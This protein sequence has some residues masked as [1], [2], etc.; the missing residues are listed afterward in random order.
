MAVS[1]RAARTLAAHF[2]VGMWL[3]GRGDV[4]R[5]AVTDVF[6]PLADWEPL[7]VGRPLAEWNIEQPARSAVATAHAAAAS[8]RRAALTIPL[9]VHRLHGW[10]SPLPGRRGRPADSLAVAWSAAHWDDDS[11]GALYSESTSFDV[12]RPPVVDRIMREIVDCV[13]LLDTDGTIR[14]VHHVYRSSLGPVA[15]GSDV[16]VVFGEAAATRLITAL[17]KVAE[18]GVTE[19]LELKAKLADGTSRWFEIRLRRLLDD[20]RSSSIIL[21]AQDITERKKG[22]EERERHDSVVRRL[23]EIQDRERRMVA[24]DIHDGLVQLVFSAKMLLESIIDAVCEP[25]RGTAQA[26]LQQLDRAMLEGRRM[27]SELRPMIVDEVGLCGAI[28]F[29]QQEYSEEGKRVIEFL[30]RVQIERLEPLLEGALFRIV[31]QAV[32]NAIVHGKA[33]RIVVRLTQIG[34]RSLITEIWDNG[35]GFQVEK[36]PKGR[37]G[38]EGI[39]ERARAFGGGCTIE[40]TIGK[41]SRLTIKV[42]LT[43]GPAREAS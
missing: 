18:R 21:S 32:Q 11:S 37:Y 25:Q 14:D 17:P 30:P 29:L 39:R 41:G 24:Y 23:V 12:T 2:P 40:S 27:I 7:P 31:Q 26:A 8:G 35:K 22:E 34:D 5:W 4:V 10:V 43:A 9:G 38:I 19:V 33:D 1:E 28:R 42:P 3:V 13:L 36:I 16:A 20:P 15:P 6:E